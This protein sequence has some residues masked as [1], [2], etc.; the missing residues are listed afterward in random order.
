MRIPKPAVIALLLGLEL[1]GLGHVSTG[2]RGRSTHARSANVDCKDWPEGEI[3]A[4]FEMIVQAGASTLFVCTG[5]FTSAGGNRLN[6]SNWTRV[7]G[8][9]QVRRHPV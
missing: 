4:A 9:G 3:D 5:H 1:M 6:Q 7:A 2:R 8:N